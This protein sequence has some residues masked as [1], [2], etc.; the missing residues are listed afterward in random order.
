MPKSSNRKGTKLVSTIVLA[1]ILLPLQPA[2]AQS[3]EQTTEQ[4]TE[5]MTEQTGG[6][7]TEQVDTGPIFSDVEPGNKY[8]VQIK[9]LKDKGLI[10]GYDDGTFK[11]AQDINR[12]EALKIITQAIQGP[13]RTINT[14]PFSFNDVNP[15]DWFYQYIFLAWQNNIV[16]GYPD[17]NFHPELTINLVEALK[18][19]LKQEG[20]PLPQVVALPPYPDVPVDAWFA[21]YA[22]VAKERSLVLPTRP[23]LNMEPAVTL[24]RGGLASLIYK[25]IKSREGSKFVRAT[26]Y[27][28]DDVNW[29][30]ASGEPF[31]NS[32]MTAAHMTLPYGTRLLVTNLA[33]GKS[34]EVT[35][36]DRGP[37]AAG[38]GLDLT[39]GAFEKIGDLSS[40]IINIEYKEIPKLGS[41]GF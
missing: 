7:V 38:I 12:A 37:T 15:A 31:N 13:E 6:E 33:N 39:G 8:Y 16:N 24:S 23:E 25:V 5:Q 30:T 17:K 29:G 2:A 32:A 20:L 3:T 9:Y 41:Y 1:A 19:A 10:E 22:K 21:P 28:Y 11:W 4:V 34:V 14:T 26:W 18:I 27:G 35:I 36:N 40:G